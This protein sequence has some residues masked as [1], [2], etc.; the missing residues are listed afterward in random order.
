MIHIS[1]REKITQFVSGEHYQNDSH[2]HGHKE[3]N[4]ST[5]ALRPQNLA[6]S[7]IYQNSPN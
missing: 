4:V 6:G 5:A 2:K 1:L 7:I 3:I